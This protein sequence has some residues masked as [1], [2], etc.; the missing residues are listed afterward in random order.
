MDHEGEGTDPVIL[1]SRAGVVGMSML[2]EL[3]QYWRELRG[4]RK[5]PVRTEVNPAQIDAILPHSFILERVAPGIGRIRVAGEA[6][7]VLLGM[8]AR[9]MPLSE[10]LATAARPVLA[11]YLEQV[12]AAPAILEL[13][14]ILPRGN[15]RSRLTA[16]MLV[17]PL[18]GSDGT[19]SRALGALV[20]DGVPGRAGRL[21]DIPED[22][23]VR[24]EVL[25]QMPVRVT[26]GRDRSH[27]KLVV[28]N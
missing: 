20:V 26:G 10:F 19:M 14:L 13:P 12:F 28:S 27:L 22:Q 5:L 2:A 15:G 8:E 6:L 24:C 21:F 9:G 4:A 17:L 11:R 25:E 18:L 1:S 23:A 3:E 7:N 16:R